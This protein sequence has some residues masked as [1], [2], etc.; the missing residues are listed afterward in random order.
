MLSLPITDF[1]GGKGASIAGKFVLMFLPQQPPAFQIPGIL[2]DAIAVGAAYLHERFANGDHLG[3]L[4]EPDEIVPVFSGGQAL[5]EEHASV[6]SVRL[7]RIVGPLQGGS[8]NASNP[9]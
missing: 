2:A 7:T 6:A 1:M 4:R 9:R 5:V 8:P 3:H